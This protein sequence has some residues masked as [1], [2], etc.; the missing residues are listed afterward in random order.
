M[1]RTKPELPPTLNFRTTPVGGLLTDYLSF[2]LQQAHILGSSSLKSGF[3]PGILLSRSQDLTTRPL[4]PDTNMARKSGRE[5]STYRSI[6]VPP[7]GLG[8]DTFSAR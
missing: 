4:H 7:V 6:L 5:V 1:T 2:L 8:E 3:E